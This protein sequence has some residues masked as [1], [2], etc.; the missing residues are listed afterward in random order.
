MIKEDILVN[1]NIVVHKRF[2]K[3][4]LFCV[5]KFRFVYINYLYEHVVS[6]GM[7]RTYSRG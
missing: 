3:S 7:K 6:E 1:L 2:K 4:N 5:N